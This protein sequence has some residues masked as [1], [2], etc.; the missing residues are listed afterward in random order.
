MANCCADGGYGA[1]L[2]ARA[3]AVTIVSDLRVTEIRD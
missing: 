2:L 1:P 3:Y